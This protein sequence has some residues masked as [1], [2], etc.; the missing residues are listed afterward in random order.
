MRI[1]YLLVCNSTSVNIDVA[2]LLEVP[3]G[4]QKLFDTRPRVFGMGGQNRKNLALER[5]RHI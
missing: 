4:D 2:N 1:E 5:R 3:V